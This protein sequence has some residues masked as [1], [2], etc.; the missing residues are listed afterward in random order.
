MVYNVSSGW[1]VVF[2]DHRVEKEIA[3]LSK[4]VRANFERIVDLIE[5]YGLEKMHE[6]QVKYIKGKIMGDASKG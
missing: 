5:G 3:A 4:D 2:A 1:I 6:P